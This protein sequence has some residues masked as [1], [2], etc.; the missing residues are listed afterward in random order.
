MRTE[1]SFA[2]KSDNLFKEEDG[3]VTVTTD[4]RAR[5][6]SNVTEETK[7][8]EAHSNSP[9]LKRYNKEKA[10]SSFSSDLSYFGLIAST[11]IPDF[12]DKV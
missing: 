6:T 7:G 10:I 9:L 12:A 3:E 8:S 2:N 5:L 4:G 11:S 1:I